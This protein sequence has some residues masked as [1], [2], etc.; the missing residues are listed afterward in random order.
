[1]AE[2]DLEVGVVEIEEELPLHQPLPQMG[3]PLPQMGQWQPLPHPLWLQQLWLKQLW[4]QRKG[5]QPPPQMLQ[6]P[7]WLQQMGPQPLPLI[8]PMLAG[9]R[10]VAAKEPT[11]RKW[12]VPTKL[13]RARCDW[14]ISGRKLQSA[15][16]AKGGPT[17]KKNFSAGMYEEEM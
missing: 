2:N 14:A 3:Q 9:G 4:L 8:L 12:G 10:R 17:G 11:G 1:M 5:A 6:V 15:R 13:K 7:L 16:Y